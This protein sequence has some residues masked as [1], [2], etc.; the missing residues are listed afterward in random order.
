MAQELTHFV[1]SLSMKAL[2]H[3]AETV[4]AVEPTAG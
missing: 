4:N 3:Q 2:R 1:D